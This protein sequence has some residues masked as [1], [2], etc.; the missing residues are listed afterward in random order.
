VSGAALLQV[1][2]GLPPPVG[3]GTIRIDTTARCRHETPMQPVRFLYG[4][5]PGRLL[6]R[7]A[8]HAIPAYSV[9]AT[10]GDA[11]VCDAGAD[12]DLRVVDFRSADFQRLY[13]EM[14]D[15]LGENLPVR[16]A[17]DPVRIVSTSPGVADTL[18]L[19]AHAAP[20]TF[21]RFLYAYCLALDRGYFSALVRYAMAGDAAFVEFIEAN[22]LQQW[23][24]ERFAQE[25]DMPVRKFNVLF[26]EKYGMSAKR[27]LLEKRLSHAREMLLSTS[28]RVLDIALECGFANHAHFTDCF[29]KRFLCNPTQLRLGEASRLV[30]IKS[31]G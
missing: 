22:C 23:S 14:V 26:Q 9:V 7:G 29:R 5:Y 16:F 27:W 2:T 20:H 1:L 24:V 30:S 12:T 10:L 3:A 25:F 18:A 4:R 28:L 8:V 15:L 17:P 19:L 6:V 21:L 31:A 13:P 11:I